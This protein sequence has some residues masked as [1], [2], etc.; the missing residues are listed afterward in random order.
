MMRPFQSSSKKSRQGV[1]AIVEPAP[2]PLARR[3]KISGDHAVLV[4][5]SV[6]AVGVVG[7]VWRLP[8][9]QIGPRRRFHPHSPARNL[10]R[11][12]TS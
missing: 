11:K 4:L 3:Q 2:A 6:E 12:I 7:T 8:R 10:H 1:T 5:W 9:W